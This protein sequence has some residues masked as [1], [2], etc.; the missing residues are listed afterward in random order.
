VEDHYVAESAGEIVGTCAAWD[1]ERL[2]QTR[3]IRFGTK[4]KLAKGAH[5][6]AARL[7]G[8]PRWPR[9][10]ER[11]KDVTIT[12]CAV[13]GRRPEILEALLRTIY[14][15]LGAKGCTMMTVGGCGGDPL[16]GAAG[17]FVSYPVVSN[18]VLFAKGPA[19]LAGDSFGASHPYVDMAMV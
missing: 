17:A 15:D 4:L 6:M 10:G 5:A 19:L 7:A 12:D 9:Q 13:R 3:I 11:I 2:R 1:M 16:L 8:F 14:N 18:I